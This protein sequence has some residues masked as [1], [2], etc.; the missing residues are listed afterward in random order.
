MKLLGVQG[1][2]EKNRLTIK[3]DM[4]KYLNLKSSDKIAI[5]K[6]DNIIDFKEVLP[7]CCLFIINS[8]KV[9]VGIS[10]PD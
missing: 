5:I 8:E 9:N 2:D 10:P 6:M 3:L 1:L 7:S 4:I